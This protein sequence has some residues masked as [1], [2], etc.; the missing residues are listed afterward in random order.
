MIKVQ[1][2]FADVSATTLLEELVAVTKTTGVLYRVDDA[3]AHEITFVGEL[4]EIALVVYRWNT[5]NFVDIEDFMRTYDSIEMAQLISY[6][7]I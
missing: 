5:G 7:E 3:Q 1:L 2:S 4:P 6:F